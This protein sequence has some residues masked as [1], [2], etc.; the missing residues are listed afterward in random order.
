MT[1]PC[2]AGQGYAAGVRRRRCLPLRG[3]SASE[4]AR[5]FWACRVGEQGVEA[6][7]PSGT[8]GR[9]ARSRGKGTALTPARFFANI[10]CIFPPLPHPLFSRDHPA[11]RP[12][13]SARTRSRVQTLENPFL[14]DGSRFPQCRRRRAPARGP[15]AVYSLHRPNRTETQSARPL[16]VGR[17]LVNTAPKA[18]AAGTAG[19][20]ATGCKLSLPRG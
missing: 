9:R 5:L 7:C 19:P 15:A 11:G 8:A 18:L 10:R 4:L 17:A 12:A 14:G 16:L 2:P 13:G 1:H 20:K 3:K 6:L